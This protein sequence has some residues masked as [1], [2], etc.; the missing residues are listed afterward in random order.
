MKFLIYIETKEG[1]PAGASLEVI[2]AA[3]SLGAE[4]DAVLIG[5]GMDAAAEATAKTGVAVTV[6]DG[7]EAPTEDFITHALVQMAKQGGYDAVLMSATPTGKIVTPRV[8]ALLDTGCVI[9]VTAIEAGDDGLVF[10][11]P[12]FGG[13]VLEKRKVTG[14]IP[15][16]CVRGGSF[17]KPADAAA[18]G[19]VSKSDITVGDDALRTKIVDIIADAGE[20]VNLEEAQVVVSGGRGMGSA[21]DFKLIIE[22]ADILGGVVG[23]TRPVIEEGWV[24][25]QHQV[26]QSGKITAPQLYICAGVSGAT[27]HVAGMSGSKYVIAINKD[28][29]APIFEVADVGIV[30]DAKKILPIFIEEVKKAKA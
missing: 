16:V 19:A 14:G 20:A 23:A 10:T 17:E 7:P 2:S 25:R 9:D 26:G 22:L 29:D 8:A 13:T 4:A 6:I 1:A 18:A 28:E 24:G 12:A 21:E 15:V 11:R 30:G 3:A 5:A 27:Q